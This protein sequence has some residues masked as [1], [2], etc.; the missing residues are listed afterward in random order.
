MSGGRAGYRILTSFDFNKNKNVPSGKKK[1]NFAHEIGYCIGFRHT[2]WSF[3]GERSPNANL[4]PAASNTEDNFIMNRGTAMYYW[5][6]L[7]HTILEPRL[8]YRQTVIGISNQV[9]LTRIGRISK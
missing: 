7:T 2:N 1:Y 5:M 6:D 9:F 3:R 8:H 4:I